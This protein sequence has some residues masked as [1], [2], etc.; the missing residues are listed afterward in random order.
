[1]IRVTINTE[2]LLAAIEDLSN[3]SRKIQAGASLALNQAASSM[4]DEI[5]VVMAAK[6]GREVGD[7]RAELRITQASPTNPTLT[8][9]ASAVVP[10]QP[11]DTTPSKSRLT[12]GQRVFPGRRRSI[13][14]NVRRDTFEAK[15]VSTVYE[16]QG[17][18]IVAIGD[19]RTCEQCM[20]M[21]GRVMS[22]EAA[23]VIVPIH[24]NCRCTI[25][26]LPET[27]LPM[28]VVM[29]VQ[30]GFGGMGGMNVDATLQDLAQTL[31]ARGG[32]M[33]LGVK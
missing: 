22:M 11:T 20:A 5:A 8:I 30:G 14:A 2:A 28:K 31:M 16:G 27:Q 29:P 9:D 21:N 26:P 12:P 17:V 13:N 32:K 7:V 10:E 24:P 3:F 1:M 15:P 33:I 19:E 6:T 4:A 23:Q 25:V 18:T